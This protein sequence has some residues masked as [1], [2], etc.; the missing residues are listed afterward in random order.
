M[1]PR[2]L[3][4]S[5]FTPSYVRE[6]SLILDRFCVAHYIIWVI[7]I[8]A[9]FVFVWDMKERP[10]T[11][12]SLSL[13]LFIF[14]LKVTENPNFLFLQSRSILKSSSLFNTSWVHFRS[15]FDVE[16]LFSVYMRTYLFFSCSIL[17][18]KALGFV[19]FL[20]YLYTQI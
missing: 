10:S 15:T 1:R 13:F 14:F 3:V 18:L 16:K 12:S 9:C 7:Y 6:T 19:G 4:G 8:Y 5:F 2:C 17:N 11:S 20:Q